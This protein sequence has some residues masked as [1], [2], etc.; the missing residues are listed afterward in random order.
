MANTENP[1][2]LRRELK[3]LQKCVPPKIDTKPDL[4]KELKIVELGPFS[5]KSNIFS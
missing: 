1:M 4:K 2:E 3:N 5:T